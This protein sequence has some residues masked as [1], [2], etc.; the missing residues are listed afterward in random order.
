LQNNQIS[1][2]YAA[3]IFEIAVNSGIVE[4]IFNDLNNFISFCYDKVCLKEFLSQ[5]YIGKNERF[6][7]IGLLSGELSLNSYFV[8]FIHLLIEN[9]RT[10]Y[11][12]KIFDEYSALRDNFLNIL[13]VKVVSAKELKQEEK[14]KIKNIIEKAFN[15]TVVIT[16]E[17]NEKIIGGYI[18]NIENISYDGSI[19][20]QADNFYNYLKQGAF[21]YGG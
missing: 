12:P 3:A 1:K 6:E 2:R 9:E 13:R 19:K 17:V 7:V 18:I 8:N 5:T 14:N 15:K 20:T 10:G 11:L 21:I 16:A 4:E